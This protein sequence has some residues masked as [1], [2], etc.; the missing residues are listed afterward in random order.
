HPDAVL[1]VEVPSARPRDPAGVVRV[2][3]L[4]P[5]RLCRPRD[6]RHRERRAEPGVEARLVER[7]ERI[8]RIQP[9]NLEFEEAAWLQRPPRLL[10]VGRDLSGVADALERERGVAEIEIVGGYALEHALGRFYEPHAIEVRDTRPGQRQHLTRHVRTPHLAE[11]AG[12]WREQPAPPPPP[13]PSDPP[14]R[15][16][17]APRPP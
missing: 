15:P 11:V 13:L 3:D 6:F 17:P 14:R 16:R 8:A 4:E 7:P 2:Q 5:G 1:D 12:H 10:D 9:D